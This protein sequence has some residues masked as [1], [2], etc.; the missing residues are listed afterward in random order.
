MGVSMGSM[1]GRPSDSAL[2]I[3][4]IDIIVTLVRL[5]E[6]ELSRIRV[7]TPAKVTIDGLG[8]T[9]DSQIHVINDLVDHES[10]TIDVRL[11]IKNDDY[12]IKPGL[13]ARVEIYPKPRMA[14]IAPRRSVL[15][16][17]PYYVFT[18]QRGY[19][20]KTEVTIREMDTQRVEITSGIEAGQHLLLGNNLSRLQDGSAIKVKEVNYVGR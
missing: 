5:P 8:Q 6:M 7:G 16:S 14:L 18:N 19:A 1:G 4:Q 9:F 10:R 15:G 11:G 13:F 3:Q 17:D 12:V 20:D 2:Q